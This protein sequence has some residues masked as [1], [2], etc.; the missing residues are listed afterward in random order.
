MIYNLTFW[1]TYLMALLLIG[2]LYFTKVKLRVEYLGF[3]KFLLSQFLISTS[4]FLL[5]YLN[6]TTKYYMTPTIG[7][8]LSM[9]AYFFICSTYDYIN[10]PNS[11]KKVMIIL[12]FGYVLY[13]YFL[14]I[15]ESIM[16]QIIALY[17]P[18]AYTFLKA[19][20]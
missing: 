18:V 13:L 12:L 10:R 20:Y 19:G 3:N 17:I 16:L 8:L 1:T 15:H 11:N 7:V 14:F 5:L 6:N 2:S 4:L 9:G